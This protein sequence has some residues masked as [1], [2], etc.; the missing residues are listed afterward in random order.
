MN[1][2]DV[3]SFGEPDEEPEQPEE[4]VSPSW[5]GPPEDELGVA[6]PQGA[7]IGR[8][9]R[10]VVALSHSIAYTTGVAFEFIAIARDLKRAETHRLFHEQHGFDPDELPDGFIRL[11][12]ELSDGSRASNIGARGSRNRMMRGDGETEGPVFMPY[13]G[14]GGSG[15]EHRVTMKPGY[16]LWPLPPLGVLKISCEWPAVAISLTTVELDADEL[17]IAARQA[18]PLWK[19]H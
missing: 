3:F 11:G 4:T 14:G 1:F 18:S 9:E 6:V 2:V 10:G 13:G 17:L 8:S 16:W 15:H 19:A 12:V 5:W 7:V